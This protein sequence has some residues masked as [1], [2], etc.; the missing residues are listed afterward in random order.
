MTSSAHSGPSA[1]AA[2]PMYNLQWNDHPNQ[3]VAMFSNLFNSTSLVDVTLAAE[4]K[5]IEAHK[6]VLSAC[7]DYFRSLFLVNPNQHPI[8]ILKDVQFEDL[9]TIVQFMYQGS[10]EVS[11]DKISGF[12][13]T[14]DTLKIQ[15]IGEKFTDE[16]N[17]IIGGSSRRLL[18]VP[19]QHSVNSRQ[20][21]TESLPVYL[22]KYVG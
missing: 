1:G 7:S 18:S 19:S 2:G 4:G 20:Y 8:V 17:K 21:S 3:L 22:D 12:I 13:K 15:G 5:H 16:A 11:S 9:K 10:V 14:A 6:M